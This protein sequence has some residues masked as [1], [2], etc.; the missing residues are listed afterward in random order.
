MGRIVITN[1]DVIDGSATRRAA[2]W[3]LLSRATG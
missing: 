3:T 1:C 2:A